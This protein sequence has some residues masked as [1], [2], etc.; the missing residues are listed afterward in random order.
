MSMPMPLSP[1]EDKPL[2]DR[3]NEERGRLQQRLELVEKANAA[4]KENDATK[5]AAA[6]DLL[7]WV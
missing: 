6:M 4:L 7:G 1:F 3:L 5:L 2:A